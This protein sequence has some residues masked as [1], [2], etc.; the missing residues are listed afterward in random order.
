M[1]ILPQ[2]RFDEMLAHLRSDRTQ[3]MCGL[4]AGTDNRVLRVLP[5]PNS[6]RSPWAYRMDGPEFVAAMQAC[7]FEPLAIFHSHLAG[8]PTPSPTDVAEATYPDSV[9]VIA[10]FHAEPP[11]VRAFSIVG[12]RVDEIEVRITT[13]DE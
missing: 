13:K 11:S 4:L 8:P 12:G 6:L 2:A 9:Y 3:E 10:S 1:L 5:V 7:D